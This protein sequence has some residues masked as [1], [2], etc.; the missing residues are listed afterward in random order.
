M[1]YGD[2]ISIVLP[3]YNSEESILYTVK[4]ILDQTYKNFELIIV[5]DGSKDSSEKII[6]KI[7]DNRIRYFYQENKGVAITRNFAINKSKSEY[8]AFI[9]S[10]DLWKNTFLERC[11]KEIIKYKC[12]IVGS[13]IRI[14]DKSK[15]EVLGNKYIK[16]DNKFYTVDFFETF[17]ISPIF[18]MSS[19]IVS[20]KA[21][22]QVGGFTEGC[23]SGE[24]TEFFS[25]LALRY[26]FGLINEELALYNR[27]INLKGKFK[28]NTDKKRG[29]TFPTTIGLIEELNM[30]NYTK[31]EKYKLNGVR[32]KLLLGYIMNLYR[33]ES[34]KE[35]KRLIVRSFSMIADKYNFKRYVYYLI[36]IYFGFSK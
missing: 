28:E 32:N 31:E 8:I 6:K 10:D 22:L 16:C 23:I 24:D 21:I 14:L 1:I 12:S 9:D 36:K 33:F 20:K 29:Q 34:K 26:E 17:L 35:A 5:N 2:K 30:N 19:I 18:T 13:R 7:L 25:K 15:N 11:I 27:I 3:V 4:S